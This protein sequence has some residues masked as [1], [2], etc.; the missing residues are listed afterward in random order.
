MKNGLKKG[1]SGQAKGVLVREVLSESGDK[2]A[3]PGGTHK[4]EF[5]EQN[6]PSPTTFERQFLTDF[7]EGLNR[8]F[9][10]SHERQRAAIN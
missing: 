7:R 10:F 3:K 2:L 4:T 9:P 8:A 5:I 1:L 6:P